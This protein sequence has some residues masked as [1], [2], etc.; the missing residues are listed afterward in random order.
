MIE[1]FLSPVSKELQDFV[2]EV[3]DPY[4]IG[5]KI[6]FNFK[7][8]K[9]KK[10]IFL[11][12]LNTGKSKNEFDEIRKQFYCLKFGD[13]H[14]EI[15]DLGDINGGN[16]ESDTLFAFNMICDWAL[17]SKSILLV[18]GNESKLIHWQHTAFCKNK[19]ANLVTVDAKIALGNTNQP[20]NN[21]NYFGKMVQSDSHIGHYTNIG[22]QSYYVAKEEIELMNQMG[23]DFFRLGELIENK[24]YIYPSLQDAHS[25]AIHLCSIQNQYNKEEEK[26]NPNGISTREICDLSYFAGLANNSQVLGLYNY[27][28]LNQTFSSEEL[29]GQILWY[30]IEGVN[31]R[32]NSKEFNSTN[33]EI[34]HLPLQEKD[35]LFYR[36]LITN[37]WWVGQKNKK[38]HYPCSYE[39]YI[40]AVNNNIS[41]RLK[42]ILK[43]II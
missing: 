16:Q 19:H 15:Y 23:Y 30:F 10:K 24:K 42:N 37:S 20:L 11:I 22:Y 32:I 18:L 28:H 40:D 25:M 2:A 21:Q 31:N 7:E 4:C 12:G 39:D 27:T 17:K 3:Q 13:W 8:S 38:N 35:I 41:N 5:K 33:F 29:V 9:N 36:D 6:Q 14:A 26:T 1:D 34:Y 43:R